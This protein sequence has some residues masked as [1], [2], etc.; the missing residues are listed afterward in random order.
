MSH[1][2]VTVIVRDADSP[3]DA[4]KQAENMMEPY[5]EQKIVGHIVPIPAREVEHILSLV[6]PAELARKTLAEVTADEE[7][8]L[9]LLRILGEYMTGDPDGGRWDGETYGYYTTSNPEGRWDWYMV[10]GR[11]QGFYNL[12]EGA[13][14]D[15]HL[16]GEPGAFFS[17][18][19]ETL[20]GCADVARKRAID[21]EGMRLMAGIEAST[22][23]DKYENVTAGIEA[24]EPWGRT[25]AR[26]V[27]K[28]ATRET[29][30][31]APA[32]ATALLDRPQTALP[33][34]PGNID[35]LSESSA[36]RWAEDTMQAMHEQSMLAAISEIKAET[37]RLS[38][39]HNAH[40]WVSALRGAEMLPLFT[41]PHEMF[42]VEEGGREAL[43]QERRDG[44]LV[45]HSLLTEHGW[46]EQGR[47]RMF[48]R[49]ED[50]MS[51]QEWVAH[52][53]EVIDSLPEDAWLVVLDAHC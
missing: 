23:Y 46:M 18:P 29:V 5:D 53:N 48:G 21:V 34:P 1:S 10:G 36:L 47:M 12:A 25:V 40:P 43:V 52:F 44:A 42:K 41:S 32:G 28:V 19:E 22:L 3:A 8:R 30:S 35:T 45:T 33:A 16:L 51:S 14:D 39:I 49:S 6:A 50:T 11:W 17:R 7:E 31:V 27:A 4:V 9:A 26:A 24:P 15:E 37:A 20:G 13:E 2:T 38:N